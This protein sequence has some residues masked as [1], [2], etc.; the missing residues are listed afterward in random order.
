ML[1]E[2]QMT[3]MTKTLTELFIEHSDITDKEQRHRYG[4]LYDR[5][6]T[7]HQPM[8]IL[9][10][11]VTWHGGGCLLCFAKRFPEARVVGVD[12]TD[13][14]IVEEVRNHPNIDIVIGN[15]YSVG[16][17]SKVEQKYKTFDLIIDDAC[18]A[19]T[20]Q[21]TAFHLW[22]RFLSPSGLYIIEDIDRGHFESLSYHL[23]Y[24][25][26][27]FQILLGDKRQTNGLP[28]SIML[29]LKRY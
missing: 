29:G 25:N 7:G 15:A 5:W 16:T 3:N 8:R 17:V 10:L 12:I 28:D 24:H 22:Q 13:D 14:K 20:E 18:H 2:L 1:Y 11:G 9:E 6:L 27:S 23:G 26:D 21:L 19:Q 4:N